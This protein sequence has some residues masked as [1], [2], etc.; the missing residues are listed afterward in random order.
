[1]NLV[2]VS[3]EGRE[4]DGRASESAFAEAAESYS[5]AVLSRLG[6][7]NWDLSLLFCDDAFIRTLNRDYREKDEATD[8]LSFGQGDTYANEAGEERI[9]AG[10]IVISL[11]AL[12]RNVAEF[13]VPRGEEL[14]R[15]VLHGILHLSGM[16]HEDNDATQPML[17]MQERLLA[18]IGPGRGAFS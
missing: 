10:D 7:I 9:L 15:L 13:S 5:L 6:K 1:M 8:V 18:E 2:V 12:D 11:Q 16:D 4:A 14:R 3:F 17:V